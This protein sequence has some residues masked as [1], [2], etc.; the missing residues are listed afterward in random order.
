MEYKGLTT[1]EVQKKIS[2]GLENS[3]IDSYTPTTFKIIFKNVLSIINIVIIP[4][5]IYLLVLKLYMEALSMGMF[6]LINTITSIVDEIRIKKEIEQL[7]SKFQLKAKVIRNGVEELIPVSEVVNEDL[8]K[9]SEGENIIANG[10]SINEYTSKPAAFA[11]SRN[12][13]SPANTIWSP[14]FLN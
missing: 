2:L 6:I 5:I 14:N 7:K 3:T 10:T 12:L 11:Y 1:L 9:V 13:P 8:V 4:L